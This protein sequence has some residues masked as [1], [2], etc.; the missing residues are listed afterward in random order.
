M[1]RKT[2]LPGLAQVTGCAEYPLSKEGF[3]GLHRKCIS[4]YFSLIARACVVSAMHNGFI[5]VT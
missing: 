3:I 4:S 1:F 2:R 5:S